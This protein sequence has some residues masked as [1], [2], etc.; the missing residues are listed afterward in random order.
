[1]TVPAGAPGLVELLFAVIT[2]KT[3]GVEDSHVTEFVR[4]LMY[5]GCEN[6]PTAR[7]FPVACRLPTVIELGTSWSDRSGTG[8]GVSVTVTDA[9]LETTEPSGFLSSA[10]MVL[11]PAALPVTSPLPEGS[12]DAI[13]AID[14]ILDA[15]W[16]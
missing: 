12:P 1:M 10:V 13:V 5:G 6:V 14:G 11:E 15:H 8:A 7:K 9:V 4:S 3:L 16:S 2:G